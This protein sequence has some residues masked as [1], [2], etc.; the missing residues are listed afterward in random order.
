MESMTEQLDCVAL[1][2]RPLP[3]AS[4][5]APRIDTLCNLSHEPSCPADSGIAPV[6]TCGALFKAAIEA[7]RSR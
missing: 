4:S 5:R 6:C 7:G 3:P 1:D 2:V